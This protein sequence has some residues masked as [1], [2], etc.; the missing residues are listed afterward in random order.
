M[1][2]KVIEA[3]NLTKRY[4]NGVVAVRVSLGGPSNNGLSGGAVRH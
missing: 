3:Q 4:L 1:T 2:E